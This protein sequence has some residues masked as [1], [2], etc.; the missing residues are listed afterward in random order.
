[1]TRRA[2]D[3]MQAEFGSSE[4]LRIM[5]RDV[6]ADTLS[7]CVAR[8]NALPEIQLAAHD[9]ET[10]EK[11]VDGVACSLVTL[12]LNANCDA[13]ALVTHLREMFPECGNTPW[14]ALQPPSWTC[15]AA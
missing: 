5:F 3:V 6:S 14:A 4:Q 9:P 10:G 13:A 1:M 15:S 2:L 11:T 7:S 8:L 12:T